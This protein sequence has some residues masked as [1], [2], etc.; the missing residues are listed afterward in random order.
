M[1]IDIICINHKSDWLFRQQIEHWHN[2]MQGDFRLVLVDSSPQYYQDPGV[3]T[4]LPPTY[5]LLGETVHFFQPTSMFDGINSGEAYDFALSLCTSDIVGMTDPDHFW[6]NPN[7][8]ARVE[9]LYSEEGY[10]CIGDAGFYRD[11]QS[12]FDV[13][14]PSHAGHLAPVLWGQFIDR[15]LALSETWVCEPPGVGQITGWRVREKIID[16]NIPRVTIPGFYQEIEGEDPDICYFGADRQKPVSVHFL[17][18]SGGRAHVMEHR[19]P[20]VLAREKAKWV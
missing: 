11:F 12:I 4:G 18:G 3:D 17:K 5:E 20:P 19:V 1:S 7:M 15:E 8:L 14:N 10:K 2:Y 9:M 6:L 13:A 16:Q